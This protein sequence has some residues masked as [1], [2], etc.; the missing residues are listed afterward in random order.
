MFEFAGLMYQYVPTSGEMGSTGSNVLGKVVMVTNYDPDAPTFTSTVQMENYDYASVAKPSIE[1]RHGVE[2]APSQRATKQLYIRAG[3]SS[4]DRLFTD[5]GTFQIASE[6]IN[7]GAAGVFNIGELW[8]TYTVKFSRAQLYSSLLGNGAVSDDFVALSTAGS[9]TGNTVGLV[10][11]TPYGT[12]YLINGLQINQYAPRLSNTIGIQVFADAAAPTASH[13]VI[14]PRNIVSGLY[15]VRIATQLPA[16]AAFNWSAPTFGATSRCSLQSI[17]GVQT[18]FTGT[19]V[20]NTISIPCGAALTHASQE[21]W[22][23]VNAPGVLQA[24]FNINTATTCSANQIYTI[25][26]SQ[27]RDALI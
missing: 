6:G 16:A 27:A 10:P 25:Q 12:R 13:Q 4:K 14:F 3:D 2:T 19:P 22:V 20:P 1:I 24:F 8:V 9:I 5:L 11:L 7:V 18:A 23:L 15:R 26:V 17:L 21:F